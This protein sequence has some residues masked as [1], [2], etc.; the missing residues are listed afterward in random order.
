MERKGGKSENEKK[1]HPARGPYFS[2]EDTH[3]AAEVSW[4]RSSG[5]DGAPGGDVGRRSYAAAAGTA[6]AATAA[7]TAITRAT[8]MCAATNSCQLRAR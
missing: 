1:E 7:A 5:G 2:M 8:T 4:Q 6:A 3:A